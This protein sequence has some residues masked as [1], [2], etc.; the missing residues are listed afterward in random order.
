MD[1]TSNWTISMVYDIAAMSMTGGRFFYCVTS[2]QIATTL[3]RLMGLNGAQNLAHAI[4]DK[5]EGL[6]QAS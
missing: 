5:E 6:V 2:F 1:R 4:G 3:R